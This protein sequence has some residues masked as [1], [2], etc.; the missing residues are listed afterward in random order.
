[1]DKDHI[2]YSR[3]IIKQ[4]F[5]LGFPAINN[6]AE[7]EVIIAG[8]KMIAT[9]WVTGLKVQSDSLLVMS[10]VKGKY[11]AKDEWMAAYL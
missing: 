7:Y 2:H 3:S 4:S 8:L 6:E 9:L 11:I 10:Q 1:M 5:T